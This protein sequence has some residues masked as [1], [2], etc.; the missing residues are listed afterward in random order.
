M[1][2]IYAGFSKT[3]TKSMQA[4]LTELGY[5]VY[6]FLEQYKYQGKEWM[7]IFKHGGTTEDFRRMFE[8][9][10]AVTDV[11]ACYFW[12][13]IHKAFPDAK[14]V[15]S[16]RDEESWV[17]SMNKQIYENTRPI[18]RILRILSPTM[19]QLVRYGNLM[20]WAVFGAIPHVPLFGRGKMNETAVRMTY[21]RHNAHVLQNAPKDKLLI[22]NVKEGWEPLCKVLGV[23]VPSKPFPHR[24]VRGNIMQEMLEKDPLFIRGQ[25]E[26]MISM[27]T[28]LAL[29]SYG[30]YRFVSSN[31][32][33]W[34]G[35]FHSFLTAFTS[36]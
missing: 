2:V 32:M 30:S 29:F 33:T 12:D 34:L 5:N 24:N 36:S 7:K 14:I 13:E 22:Y 9:V 10:D 27:A 17:K 11:P 21:R 4:A 20:S 18:V 28:L 6:D 3:G 16:I 25:R 15:F 1:K 31:P 19:W 8:N 26:V 35:R 23:D